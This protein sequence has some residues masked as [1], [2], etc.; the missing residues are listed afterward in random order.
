MQSAYKQL[1]SSKDERR[2]LVGGSD[3]A[4]EEK[5]MWKRTWKMH[6]KGKLKHFVWRCYNNIF[7]TK[8]QFA[9]KGM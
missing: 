9:K 2:G 4:R 7:P 1:Q 3:G 5:E 6:S 8:V